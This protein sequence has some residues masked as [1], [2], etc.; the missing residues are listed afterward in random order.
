MI[1]IVGLAFALAFDAFGV[2]I[3]VGVQ[4]G[5]LD[6]WAVFRL[7]FHF[8]FAQF[9][10]PIIGWLAG[11]YVY[12]T[13][14][15]M[16]NWLAAAVLMAI[17]VRLI[18]EQFSPEDKKWRGDPT[19]GLSLILL[20]LATSIDAL[21]AGLSLAL[22]GTEILFPAVVIGIVAAG[23]TIVGLVFGRAVQEL[24]RQLFAA[25]VAQEQPAKHQQR[26]HRPGRDGTDR[27]CDGHQD[28]LVEQRSLGH[29]PHDR[30]LARG[31]DPRQLLGVQRQVVAQHARGLL[32]GDLAEHRHVVE[33]GGDVVQQR[34]EAG[35]GHGYREDSASMAAAIS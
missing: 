32:G 25:L 8:G 13:V 11:A 33:D 19:R 34:K 35:A 10:M 2:A 30:Q 17:G 4:L 28:R 6:R 9:G 22:V 15:S 5:V 18:W 24:V 1:N 29:R 31:A 20:M 3:A 27:Q 14:G 23:M 21:A 12:E 26:Q 16:G 7:S